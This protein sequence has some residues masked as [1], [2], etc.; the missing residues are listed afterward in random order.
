[1]ERFLIG[2]ASEILVGRGLPD[3]LLPP[4]AHRRKAAILTQPTVTEKARAIADRLA[5]TE[6]LVTEVVELA[7]RESA[8][9]LSAL[10]G[11]YA[12]LARMELGRDDVIIAVGGGAATDTGG[13]VAATW[14]RGVDVVHVPTTLLGAVDAAIGGK[15]AV[16]LAGKNLVGAFWHPRRVAIDLDT[17][18]SLPEALKREGSAEAIKTGFIG[19]PDIVAAYLE[20][21]L[22]AP[23]EDVVPAS[24]A[25][26]TSIVSG[27]FTEKGDRALLNLG[28]T[29]GH[30][31]E[32]ASNLSHGEAVAIGLVAAA[33]ISEAKLGFM[34][35]GRVV[36][37]L[38]RV[39]LP[40][41][42]PELSR[43][44]VIRLVALDKKRDADGLR[45]VLLTPDGGVEVHRV[46][47]SDLGVGLD[48][49]GL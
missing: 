25:V 43:S 24:V 26:K 20:H 8:K 23:V 38:K 21:G 1:M 11:I 39:G 28:H 9:S 2:D 7:D 34:G 12:A 30:G 22:D 6:G 32:F 3:P 27:D 33:A 16:N 46:D 36:E 45:M 17:M 14:L 48:A 31:I 18:E 41:R 5:T 29:I 37:V 10:E 49:V 40:V 19:A 13:F 44:D 42:S 4:S 47:E 35:T 15:T